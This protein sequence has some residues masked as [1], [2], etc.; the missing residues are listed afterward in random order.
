MLNPPFCDIV[1]YVLRLTSGKVENCSAL[2]IPTGG[3]AWSTDETGTYCKFI[4]GSLFAGFFPLSGDSV[5]YSIAL[6]L[7][8]PFIEYSA[9]IVQRIIH[10][11]RL[12]NVRHQQ[13][14]LE[15]RDESFDQR[16]F[17]HE[18]KEVS[19][20]G[21]N[22]KT[23]LFFLHKRWFFWFINRWWNWKGLGI[24]LKNKIL[25]HPL[26]IF[27]NEDPCLMCWAQKIVNLPCGAGY[28]IE[29]TA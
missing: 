1:D 7:W 13:N 26:D 18:Y 24:I 20:D 25:F 21:G 29:N 11:R 14:S 12:G 27:D 5:S 9:L 8:F 23:W 10:L 19:V 16:G 6:T 28:G 15:I 17:C 2:F 3:S 4:I 22:W